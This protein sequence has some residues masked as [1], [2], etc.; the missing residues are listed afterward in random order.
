MIKRTILG[1]I[2]IALVSASTIASAAEAPRLSADL[3]KNSNDLQRAVWACEGGA[4]S[5]QEG[6]GQ[7]SSGRTRFFLGTVGASASR[8]E[9]PLTLKE[10]RLSGLGSLSNDKGWSSIRF[11]CTLSPDLRKPMA[12][13]FDILSPIPDS[14]SPPDDSDAAKAADTGKNW[15]VDTS[16]PI[17]LTHG[18]KETDDRDFV[19]SCAKSSGKIQVSLTNTVKWL[20][21]GNYVTVGISGGPGSGLYVGRGVIDDNL[22][23]AMPVFKA[24]AKDPLLG[25]IA[26]GSSLHIN[27]G[28]EST[29]DVS[30]K[31]SAQA[32]RAFAAACNS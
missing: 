9:Q 8:S 27:L 6:S 32:A 31:G 20:K 11:D 21:D 25:W 29:Y 18:V 1:T 28:G 30:L 4:T 10:N 15:Y 17:V 3:S 14:S 19:A 5:F 16:G 12:F 7:K 23:V 2:Q 22:G 13:K 26:S 24:S